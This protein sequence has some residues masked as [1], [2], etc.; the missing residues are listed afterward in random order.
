MVESLAGATFVFDYPPQAQ[1]AFA[2]DQ[3]FYPFLL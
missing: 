2:R 3:H 1:N